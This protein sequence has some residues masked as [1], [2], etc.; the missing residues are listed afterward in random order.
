MCCSWPCAPAWRSTI[1]AMR[2]SC[3]R[4]CCGATSRIPRRPHTLPQLL[5]ACAGTQQL[6][7]DAPPSASSCCAAR[8]RMGLTVAQAAE[9]HARGYRRHRG[10]GSRTLPRAGCAGVRA[11]LPAPAT[12]SCWANRSRRCTGRYATLEE[13]SAS[14]DISRQCRA[15]RRK[16]RARRARWPLVVLAVLLVL[17]VAR[18]VGDGSEDR[19][20]APQLAAVRGMNDVLPA[21][22]GAWQHLERVT[23]ELFAAYGYEEMRVP[24]VEQTGAVQARHRRV[25]RHRREGDVH[26]HRCPT[27]KA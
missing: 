8:E 12:P 14:P 26:L 16:A 2:R 24:M 21:E 9:Q 20:S 6:M 27:A 25:H 1:A 17:A 23:R 15:W 10:A 13:S 19:L 4:G 11:R 22:I 18:L 5:G 7:S 3:M